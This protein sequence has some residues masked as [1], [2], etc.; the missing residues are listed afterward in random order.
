[1]DLVVGDFDSLPVP[2]AG[3]PVERHPVRKDDT[4]MML[5]VKLG[6]QAGL[7]RFVLYGGL[8]GRL[9]HTL[10]NIQ[11]LHYL[12]R[13]G[14]RGFLTDDAQT[15]TVIGDSTLTFVPHATG[16]VSVF[17]L[18]DRAVVTLTGLSYPVTDQVLT[19]DVPLGVSNAFTGAAAA[20]TVSEGAVLVLWNGPTDWALADAGQAV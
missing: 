10:A 18:T 4:D 8:G 5:A 7:D 12:C 14:A 17:A 16:T 1:M 13:R 3:V 20:V 15:M 9:D 11:T 6:L 19:P 2:P